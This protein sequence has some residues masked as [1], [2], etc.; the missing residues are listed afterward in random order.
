MTVRAKFVVTTIQQFQANAEDDQGKYQAC[1]GSKIN[2]S[3]VYESPSADSTDR[4][5]GV[6][7]NR[8]FG[9]ATPSAVLEMTIM[10]ETAAAQFKVGKPFYVDFT[11]AE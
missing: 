3:A 4:G 9:R 1:V 2:M 8:I 10:N 6:T 7:E 5:N 11:L